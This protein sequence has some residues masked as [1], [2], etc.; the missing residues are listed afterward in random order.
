[1]PASFEAFRTAFRQLRLGKT[2]LTGI[3]R[4]ASNSKYHPRFFGRPA[5]LP[6]HHIQ[7]ALE[8][9]APIVI[10]VPVR[11]PDGRIAIASSEEIHMQRFSSREREMLFNAE[12]VLEVAEEFIRRTPEQWGVFQPVWP[13]ALVELS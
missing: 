8:T 11:R 6:L 12:C 1:M 10:F 7:L 9:G 5:S 2:I 13:E 4:P 3:D